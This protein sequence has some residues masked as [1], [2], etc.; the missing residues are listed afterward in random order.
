MLYPDNR[1]IHRP[2]HIYKDDIL[3]FITART[4]K[5][6]K[7]FNAKEKKKILEKTLKEILERYC[8]DCFALAILDNHYHIIIKIKNGDDLKLFIKDLHSLSSQRLNKLEDKKGRKIWF[9]YWDHCIRNE[10]DFFLHFNYIHHN[11]VKHGYIKTQEE[12]LNYEFCS[13]KDWMNK[14]GAEWLASSFERYP[15]KDFTVEGDDF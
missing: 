15:I 7:F 5:K 8:C 12:V 13:Y 6:E 14:K 11:P 2:P 3:Y 10:K 9:Q 4:I 1:N